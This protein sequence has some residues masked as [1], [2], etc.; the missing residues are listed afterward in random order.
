MIKKRRNGNNYKK[1][2]NILLFHGT[3]VTN[4]VGILEKGFKS[5]TSGLHG[6]GVYLTASSHLAMEYSFKKSLK[7]NNIKEIVV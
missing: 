6:P 4:A 7:A 1:S 3:S 5:S 2:D